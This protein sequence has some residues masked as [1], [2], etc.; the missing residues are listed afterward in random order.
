MTV[1]PVDG[2][3]QIF[4]TNVS[5]IQ[6]D[7]SVSDGVIT[8]TSKWLASGAIADYWGAGNFLALK[9]SDFSEG[10]TYSDVQVGLVPTQGAGMVTLDSDTDGVF[11][12]LDTNQKLKVVQTGS[13]GSRVQYFSF[14]GL[15]LEEEE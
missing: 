9:F 14:S 15:T 13:D 4:G 8:G 12:V 3:S 5:D 2:S 10:I 6:S 7:I 1:A 11:K